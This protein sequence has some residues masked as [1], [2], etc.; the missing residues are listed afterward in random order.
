[1]RVFAIGDL[2][3]PGGQEKPMNVFGAQWDD[4]FARIAADWRDK[5]GE[6]DLVLIPGDISWAMTLEQAEEDLRA[7]GALPGGKLILRGN[8]DYWWSSIG[9]VR[10][11]LPDGMHALQNDA[12]LSGEVL[13]AGTRGWQTPGSKEFEAADEKI[14]LRE[15][16]RLELSLKDARKKSGTLPIL[17]ILH[18]PP[19]NEQQEDNGFTQLLEGYGV[20]RALY[21]HL[22]GRSVHTAFQGVR[23]GIDYRLV[24]CDALQFRLLPIPM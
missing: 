13:I 17:A 20:A 1:M 4:H 19:F 6:G 21:G 5:V 11:A 24:S 18:Y 23:N 14:Y 2:H 16:Q 7:I 9:R 12:F 3:L 10:A 15:V 8:H 22:H